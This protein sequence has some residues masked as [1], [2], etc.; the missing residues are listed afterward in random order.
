MGGALVATPLYFMKKSMDKFISDK[1]KELENPNL[2]FDNWMPI[3]IAYLNEK[4]G[5]NLTS[6]ND[7]K[8]LINKN[9]YLLYSDKVFNM[10]IDKKKR[11]AKKIL[12]GVLQL[13][14]TTENFHKKDNKETI[15]FN[16]ILFYTVLPLI[17]GAT[18][19][20]GYYFGN[21]K[22]DR[23]K[24][25]L[26]EENKKQK[27]IIDSLKGKNSLYKSDSTEQKKYEQKN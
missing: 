14:S 2:D 19:T 8:N 21:N 10:N 5:A 6:T 18:F 16:K 9:E 13:S 4:Y 11:A 17:I 1:I 27:I 22:F 3:V 15:S 12:T 26:W 25:N 7:L 20:L 23:E 24:L